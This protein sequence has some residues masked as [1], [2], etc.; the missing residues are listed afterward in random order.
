MD[1]AFAPLP[2]EDVTRIRTTMRD[3]YDQPIE[4]HTAGGS[5]TPCRHCLR[6]IPQGQPYLILAHRPFQTRNPYAET[7]PSFSAR[8]NARRRNPRANLPRS[9]PRP[10]I[11]CAATM[12]P[13]GS[14]TVAAR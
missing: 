3:A 12:R 6:L 9:S 2:T 13:S 8:Q 7:G 5:A 10:A 14:S 11:W 1:I 4:I